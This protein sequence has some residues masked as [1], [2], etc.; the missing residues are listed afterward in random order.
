[1]KTL[2][3]LVLLFFFSNNSFSQCYSKIVSYSRNYIAL[4]TDGTLWSKGTTF[5]RRLLGFGDVPASAE[6]AQIGTDNNWTENI[7][8]TSENIFAIKTD[9]TLWVWGRIT[10]GGSA[11]LGTFDELDYITPTQVGTDTN[12]AKVSQGIAFTLGIKTDGTLWAWGIN[13]GGRL[14]IANTDD[15][16]KTSIPIQVGTESNWS[17]VFTGLTSLAFAIKTDGTLWSWGNN[18]LY[19]GYPNATASNNYRSPKQVGTDTWQ[20][21]AVGLNGPMID[22]IKTD[23]TLWGWGNSV[24]GTYRFGDGSSSY[25]SEF[26]IQIG[27]A[28]DWKEICLSQGTTMGLKT[29]GTRW[30][31]GRNTTGQQMGIGT[32]VSGGF[33]AVPTQLGD[34]TDWKK[35]SIDLDQGYG[36]GIK[37]NN[38]LYHWG[39]TNTN[40]IYP[41]PTLFSLNNCTLGTSDFETNPITTYPNPTTDFLHIR[42]NQTF[43]QN[44]EINLFNQL[45]QKLLLQNAETVNQEIAL[46]LKNY[47][48]GV[49]F[50]SLKINGQVYKTKIIKN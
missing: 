31:W 13:S 17:N 7:S 21:I 8:I 45:G 2:K 3:L 46:D 42:F 9:G 34:D 25:T 50:L 47:V 39:V 11:G 15:S 28:S 29:N 36:E 1:M 4:Q 38:S 18:G 26:P 40:L 35:L 22:G 48:S 20:T 30:G 41:L 16:Y 44:A 14:G 37:E 10:T 49:Y 12:W 32:G 27:T 43:G 33:I 5:D 19:L 24:F 23:G 6:F